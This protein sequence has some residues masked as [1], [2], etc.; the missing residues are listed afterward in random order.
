MRD[1]RRKTFM[2]CPIW[3]ELEARFVRAAKDVGIVAGML[4]GDGA[5]RWLRPHRHPPPP[6]RLP[7]EELDLS[8]EQMT[9]AHAIIAPA[10]CAS[11]RS[12]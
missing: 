1:N 11:R 9:Q 2:I 12:R 10:P 3:C 6:M 8:A 4:V 5:H 7:I